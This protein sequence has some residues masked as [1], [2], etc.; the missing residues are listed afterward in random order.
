MSWFFK[1]SKTSLKGKV[2]PQEKVLLFYISSSREGET[3]GNLGLKDE[4]IL[5]D[6]QELSVLEVSYVRAHRESNPGL[7]V[8]PNKP[9]PVILS[10]KLWALLLFVILKVFNALQPSHAHSL[11]HVST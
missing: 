9:K 2:M 10:T 7:Q 5:D 4:H 11:L 6:Y 3:S 1:E 8:S